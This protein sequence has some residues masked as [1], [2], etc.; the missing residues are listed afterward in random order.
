MRKGTYLSHLICIINLMKDVTN[1][2]ASNGRIFSDFQNQSV[3]FGA[4]FGAHAFTPGA[5]TGQATLTIPSLKLHS[6]DLCFAKILRHCYELSLFY[7][8]SKL[9]NPFSFQ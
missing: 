6:L 9:S 7:C 5:R 1:K 2:V 4:I 8:Q 3:Q